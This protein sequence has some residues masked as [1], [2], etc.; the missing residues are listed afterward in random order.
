MYKTIF[1]RKYIKIIHLGEFLTLALYFIVSSSNFITCGD[2]KDFQKNS[3]Y[4][5]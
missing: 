5:L 1:Y 4:L 2:L 3:K